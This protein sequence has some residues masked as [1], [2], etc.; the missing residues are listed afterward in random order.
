MSKCNA[1]FKARMRELAIT[2]AL[3]E[4]HHMRPQIEVATGIAVKRGNLEDR[5]V[6]WV[7]PD[8]TKGGCTMLVRSA[9]VQVANAARKAAPITHSEHPR[10]AAPIKGDVDVI[11]QD[12]VK[13]FKVDTLSCEEWADNRYRA[14]RLSNKRWRD[15]IAAGTTK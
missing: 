13:P 4:P 8:G 14:V 12:K 1:R 9:N 3:H 7:K 5:K 10:S 15:F 2:R 11:L 6:G